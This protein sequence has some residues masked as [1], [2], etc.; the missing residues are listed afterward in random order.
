MNIC[1]LNFYNKGF[2][3]TFESLSGELILNLF[4]YFNTKE[5]LES[6]SNVTPLITS[7]I[8]DPRRQLHLYVDHEM[9][10]LGENYSPGQVISVY[11]NNVIIPIGIF[12][13]LKSLSIIY[14]NEQ[15]NECLQ[16][17]NEVS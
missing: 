12:H 13:N 17:I 15:K 10:Y 4:E 6:F 1:H 14:R 7:C 16:M 9:S 3:S 8:F 2:S 11:M 5:I